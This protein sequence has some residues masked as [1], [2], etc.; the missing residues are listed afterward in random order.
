[1]KSLYEVVKKEHHLKHWGRLQLGLFFKGIG[2]SVEEATKFWRS[3]FTRRPEI[4]ASRVSK[5]KQNCDF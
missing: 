2:V 5:G 1:M 4:D 3:H